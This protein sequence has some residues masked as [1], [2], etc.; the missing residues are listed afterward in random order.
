MELRAFWTVLMR[1][2]WVVLAVTGAA[3]IASG[4]LAVIQPPGYRAQTIVAFSVPA[5]QTATSIPGLDVQNRG[6]FAEQA[7]DDFTK[8]VPTHGFAE[9]VAKRLSTPM[10][11]R[12]VQR[13]F[14]AKKQAH[15]LV[16]IEAGGPT[17]ERAVELAKAAA[18]EISQ[19]GANYFRALNNQDMA[20]AIPD[21]A[22]SEGLA[23]RLVDYAFIAARIA[24]GLIVG[25]GLAFLLD[26]LDDRINS[27]EDA[28]LIGLP[29]I[30]AI[31]RHRGKLPAPAT[32]PDRPVSITAV[33]S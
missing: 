30:G 14:T 5:A 22:H 24:V 23:G 9:G 19:N 26:Y 12:L 7:A 17:E 13:T 11:P 15:H 29:V 6:L 4:I 8:I 18:D 2:R 25:V 33:G 27:A 21:P 32:P 3:V 10:D 31:P 20:V 1:W 16:S 28:E